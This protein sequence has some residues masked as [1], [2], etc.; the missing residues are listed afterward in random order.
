MFSRFEL[1]KETLEEAIDLIISEKKP[2]QLVRS[3]F[4]LYDK[5]GGGP[6]IESKREIQILR[7]TPAFFIV[8]TTLRKPK[9]YGKAD[10]PIIAN[11]YNKLNSIC[12][13]KFYNGEIGGPAIIRD[14][15]KKDYPIVYK[16]VLEKRGNK[17]KNVTSNLSGFFK[18]LYDRNI[19]NRRES[20]FGPSE[21][22]LS[23]AKR[24]E[25]LNKWEG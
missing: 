7:K 19:I 2:R 18:S 6:F 11:S 14:K 23:E 5:I 17:T 1:D 12:L 24:K 21:Y 13:E 9:S 16:M 22:F 10:V 25:I 4:S 15:V 3:K 20:N 8:Y